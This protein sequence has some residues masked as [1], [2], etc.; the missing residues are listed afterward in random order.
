M[1]WK[2]TWEGTIQTGSRAAQIPVF[3]HTSTM[4]KILT[5]YALRLVLSPVKRLITNPVQSFVESKVNDLIRRSTGAFPQLPSLSKLESNTIKTL[6]VTVEQLN[7][8]MTA[9]SKSLDTISR[10]LRRFAFALQVSSVLALVTSLLWI[11]YWTLGRS[12]KQPQQLNWGNNPNT[13]IP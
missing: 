3:F 11:L 6:V 5:A 12:K 10:S 1:S 9:H 2:L 7:E 4:H 8:T 13:R